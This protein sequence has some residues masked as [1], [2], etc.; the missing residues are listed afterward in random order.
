MAEGQIHIHL[1]DFQIRTAEGNFHLQASRQYFSLLTWYTGKSLSIFRAVNVCPAY[2]Y[3]YARCCLSMKLTSIHP[4]TSLLKAFTFV[5]II[6]DSWSPCTT[7]HISIEILSDD[8][9]LR[10]STR[11]FV[12]SSQMPPLLLVGRLF[13]ME[14]RSSA[15]PLKTVVTG[16]PEVLQRS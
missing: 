15:E 8:V 13:L 11:I 2:P 3:L 10:K 12:A 1:N 16:L 4:K 5:R 6:F 14:V 9:E 7:I